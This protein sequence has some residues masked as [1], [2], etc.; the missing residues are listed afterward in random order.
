MEDVAIPE[1]PAKKTIPAKKAKSKKPARKEFKCYR[2]LS[3]RRNPNM[4]QSEALLTRDGV[5]ERSNGKVSSEAAVF[6]GLKVDH[7][8]LTNEY[9]EGMIAAFVLIANNLEK[10]LASEEMV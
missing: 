8:V 2:R 7:N 5:A 3:F 6:D 1:I 9:H 4:I 10:W